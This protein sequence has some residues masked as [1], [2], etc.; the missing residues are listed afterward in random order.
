M[1]KIEKSEIFATQ[2]YESVWHHHWLKERQVSAL[3]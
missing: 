2:N 1:Q 3:S